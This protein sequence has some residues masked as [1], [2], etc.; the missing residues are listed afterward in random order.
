MRNKLVAA[1]ALGTYLLLAAAGSTPSQ[2]V[3]SNC[4]PDIR[5]SSENCPFICWLTAIL[6]YRD[7]QTG[8]IV[9]ECFYGDCFSPCSPE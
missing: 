8:Q 4:P 2:A 9:Y 5:G 1:V 3:T 7:P 6:F